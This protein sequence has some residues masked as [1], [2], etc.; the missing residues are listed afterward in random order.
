MLRVTRTAVSAIFVCVSLSSV[1][2]AGTIAPCDEPFVYEKAAVN[3][4]V[5]PHSY[6][7]APGQH[8]SRTGEK[9]AALVQTDTL[10]SILKFKSIGVVQLYGRP[11]DCIPKLVTGKLLWCLDKGF[12]CVVT[13]TDQRRI[14]SRAF[15]VSR[16]FDNVPMRRH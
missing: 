12:F 3:M 6:L 1:A 7:P 16:D 2:H 4:V 9:L 14:H 5:L 11:E 10:Y 15:F 8:F 13:K